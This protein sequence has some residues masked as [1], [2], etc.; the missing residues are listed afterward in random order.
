[1]FQFTAI[2]VSGLWFT[3]LT[4]VVLLSDNLFWQIGY[5]ILDG[6]LVFQKA[7]CVVRKNGICYY[8]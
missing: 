8:F 6:W 7:S 4:L 2:I 1:M 5:I 3:Y